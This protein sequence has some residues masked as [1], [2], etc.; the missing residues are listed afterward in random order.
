MVTEAVVLIA[1]GIGIHSLS[2]WLERWD[3]E[4]HLGD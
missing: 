1:M 3:Y 2:T 4:R